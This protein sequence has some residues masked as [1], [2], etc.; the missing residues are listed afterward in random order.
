MDILSRIKNT[1]ESYSW[2]KASEKSVKKSNCLRTV[3]KITKYSLWE[4]RI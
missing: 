4:K 1:K 3:C 2:E